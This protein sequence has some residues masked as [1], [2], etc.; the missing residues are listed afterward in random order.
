MKFVPRQD[1]N[2]FDLRLKFG[3][4]LFLFL[5]FIVFIF[6]FKIQVIDYSVY[7]LKDRKTKYERD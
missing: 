5:F 7:S 3:K 1:K 2:D 6:L 4:C